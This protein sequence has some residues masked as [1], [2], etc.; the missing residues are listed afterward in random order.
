M[1]EAVNTLLLG[2]ISM[3]KFYMELLLTEIQFLAGQVGMHIQVMGQEHRTRCG[4]CHSA[5][6]EAA[7]H[8]SLDRAS[9][10]A[11]GV[12]RE[13][14]I[15]LTNTS[16]LINECIQVERF[17]VMIWELRDSCMKQ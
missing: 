1:S 15:Q 7:V 12:G 8:V 5:P 14:S 6:P 11:N 4:A 16:Y 3:T 17:K 9:W 10:S 2:F 13:P